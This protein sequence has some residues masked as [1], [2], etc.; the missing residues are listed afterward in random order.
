MRLSDTTRNWIA[1]I[2][3]SGLVVAIFLSRSDRS[4][5]AP[6]AAPRPSV[7]TYLVMVDQGAKDPEKL[8]EASVQLEA[9]LEYDPLDPVAMFG[10]GWAKQLQ[11]AS[12]E[13]EH[14]Y[15]AT[16]RELSEL[17]KFSYYNRSFIREA[18][19]DVT[20]ALADVRAAL[21]LAPNFQLAQERER[22]LKDA[23]NA[24]H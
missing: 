22:V 16:L 2:L 12:A 3:A 8:S 4:S 15:E 17:G 9:A 6:V 1:G 14:W 23:Q 10:L 20:G 13:A 24:N 21:A 5:S 18:R 11:G 7:R 19:G